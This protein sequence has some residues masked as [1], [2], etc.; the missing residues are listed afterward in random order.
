M[1]WEEYSNLLFEISRQLDQ[2]NVREQLHFMCRRKVLSPIEDINNVLSLFRELEDQAHLEIDRLEVLKEL[3]KG[4]GE[5]SLFQKVKK[6]EVKRKEFNS[7]LRQIS[8][9]LD[10]HN[11]LERLILICRRKTPV[12][13]DGNIH[14]VRFLF[15]ELER[16]NFLGFARLDF[17]KEILTEIEEEDLLGTVQDFERRRNEEDEFERRKGKVCFAFCNSL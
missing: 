15:K 1:S 8:G 10:E 9:V 2:L 13:I 4:V 7:L 12:E 6:F 5:W 3:L 14:D 11:H 17:L 16:Q